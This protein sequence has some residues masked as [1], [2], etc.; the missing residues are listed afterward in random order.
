LRRGII[1]A[2]DAIEA[3]RAQVWNAQ[4]DRAGNVA[5]RVA[6]FVAIVG[7]IRQLAAADAVED[8]Q[9][10]ARERCQGWGEK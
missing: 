2:D 8:D 1:E 6:A 7:G 3:E 4:A 9:D 5:E 10:D